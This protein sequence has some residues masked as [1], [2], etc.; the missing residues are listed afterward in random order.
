MQSNIVIG[1]RLKELCKEKDITYSQLAVKSGMP[2]KRIYRMACG[3]N[4]NPGVFTMLPICEGL[5]VTLDE[6]CG[7]EEFKTVCQEQRIKIES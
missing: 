2:V 3:M 7:T 5:G 1:N 4:S 6:F